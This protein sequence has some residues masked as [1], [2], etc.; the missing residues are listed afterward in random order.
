MPR[1]RQ[2]TIEGYRS[3]S[4]QVVINFPENQPTVLIGENNSGKSNIIRA[5][6]LM[7]GEFHPK[8]KKLD[9]Y[10]HFDRDPQ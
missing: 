7:F 6:E 3:I 8:Y 5:I 1:L 10:D 2:I 4:E 9:D